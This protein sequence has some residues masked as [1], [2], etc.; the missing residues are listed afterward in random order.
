LE[1]LDIDEMM[2]DLDQYAGGR[3]VEVEDEMDNQRVEIYIE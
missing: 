1:G 3:I 2:N